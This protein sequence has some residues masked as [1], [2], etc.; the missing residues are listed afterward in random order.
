MG[1]RLGVPFIN[2]LRDP[3]HPRALRA[4]AQIW[5]LYHRLGVHGVATIVGVLRDARR[6]FEVLDDVKTMDS[7]A[8]LCLAHAW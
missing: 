7:G 6:V 1:G 8:A 5:R 2:Y 3:V 4:A